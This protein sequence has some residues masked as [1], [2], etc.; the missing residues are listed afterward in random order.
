MWPICSDNYPQNVN[1]FKK[2]SSDLKTLSPVVPHPND[3]K[4]NLVLLFNAVHIIK[5]I[6]NNW[7]NTKYFNH[8]FIYPDIDDI[9][10]EYTKYLLTQYKACFED[11]R[12]LYKHE[13]HSFAKVA[14][15]LTA[16]SCWPLNVKT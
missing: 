14:D 5:S 9:S 3:S 10:I 2:F 7:L 11:V 13:Q 8:T 6:R 4:R 16:K 15:H 1:I 12:L